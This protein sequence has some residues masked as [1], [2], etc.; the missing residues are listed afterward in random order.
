MTIFYSILFSLEDPKKNLYAHLPVFLYR[1]LHSS[2]SMC[3]GDVY[4]LLCD[5]ETADVMR[6]TNLAKRPDVKILGMTAP[7]AIL[8]GMLMRYKFPFLYDCRGQTCV[9]LDLDLIPIKPIHFNLEKADDILLVCPEGKATDTNYCGEV[10]NS[11]PQ[12]FGATSGFF[13]YK[14]GKTV[15]EFFLR[16]IDR[17]M[18]GTRY[19]FYYTLDQP[20][21]NMELKNVKL[22]IIPSHFLSFNGHGDNKK[23]H[24]INCCGEPGDAHLHFSKILSFYLGI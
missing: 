17:C 23:A 16:V 14:A 15:R 5:H 24:L 21:F 2:K 7:A 12:T 18:G 10:T 11:L 22:A 6:K 4:V 20:F 9:Y 19:P 13:A 1:S 8:D 3:P